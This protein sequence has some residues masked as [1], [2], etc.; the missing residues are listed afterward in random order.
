MPATQPL[1]RSEYIVAAEL[2]DAGAESRIS[3]AAPL[4]TESFKAIVA[5]D[6]RLVQTVEWDGARRSVRA[7]ERLLLGALV[8]EERPVGTIDLALTSSAVFGGVRR[9][10]IAVLPWSAS[11][12][13]VRQRLACLHQVDPTWPDQGDECLLAELEDWLGTPAHTGDVSRIDCGQLLLGRLTADQRNRFDRMAPDRY[14]VPTGSQIEID[15]R[16]PAAPVLAV[17]L[18]EMFGETVTPTIADGRLAVTVHLLS[19]AGRPLQVTRDL[20]GFWRTSYFDV[21]REMKGRYPKHPWPDNPLEATPT[22][23][24]KRRA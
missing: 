7:F 19:P 13:R 22:R 21:R 5:A 8:I 4:D 3:I 15:Y 24:T 18:Q 20:S 23:R 10:G 1:A 12:I 9:D 6:S 2:D 11:A 16:D 14:E 17:K